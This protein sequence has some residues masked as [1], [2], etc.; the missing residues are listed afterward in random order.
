MSLQE[1]RTRRFRQWLAAMLLAVA[2]MSNA[3]IHPAQAAAPPLSQELNRVFA[4]EGAESMLAAYQHSRAAG[5]ASVSESDLDTRRLASDLANAGQLETAEAL[6]RLNVEVHPD[7]LSARKRLARLLLQRHQPEAAVAQYEQVLHLAPEDKDARYALYH[8]NGRWPGPFPAVVLV[9]I[10]GGLLGIAA[11]FLAMAARKGRGWHA[12]AGQVFVYAMITMSV[13]ASMRALGRLPDEWINF[14]MGLVALYLV[15]SS[16]HAIRRPAGAV[17]VHSLRAFAMFAVIAVIGLLDVARRGGFFA[18]PA[19]VF[20]SVMVIAAIGDWRLLRSGVLSGKGRLI[21][22]LW[23]MGMA[24]F[25]AVASFFL[26]Q[27]Q[28]F[29]FAIQ[30]SGVLA[31]PALLVLLMILYWAIRYRFARSHAVPS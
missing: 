15:L 3:T 8:L 22:H 21:R 18:A 5:F 12:R 31:V 23:R 20:G 30:E 17:S 26:G 25:I 28:V 6:L 14:W 11:G 7:S 1:Y 13:S 24:M 2:G 27:T 19:L 16:W 29:P 4:D 9:H 10:L